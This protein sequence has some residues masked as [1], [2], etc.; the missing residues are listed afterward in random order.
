MLRADKYFFEAPSDISDKLS[1]YTGKEVNVGVRPEDIHAE[2][3]FMGL[4]KTLKIEADIDMAE[5]MGAELYAYFDFAGAKMI[6]R[7][8]SRMNIVDNERLP[9]AIGLSKLHIFDKET[10]ISLRV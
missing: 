4:E 3:F 6:S 10:G 7:I 5:M 8:P 1:D 2:D 9:L